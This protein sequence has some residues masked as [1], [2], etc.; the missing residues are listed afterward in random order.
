[1]IEHIFPPRW[2]NVV[3]FAV[4]ATALYLLL[5]WSAQAR[6]MRLSLSIV[7]LFATANLAR[8]LDLVITG[9]VIEASAWIMT[10]LLLI[11][12]Q[13]ELR[14][15]VM[16]VEDRFRGRVRPDAEREATARAIAGAALALARTRTGA[17]I[18]VVGNNSIEELC[19][20]GVELEA[21]V[22]MDLLVA[23][24]Q[25]DSPLH[26]GAVIIGQ[27][28]IQRAGA[29]LPL[30]QRTDLPPFYGTRHRAAIGLADRS[31]ARVIVVSEERGEVTCLRQQERFHANSESAVS[32]WLSRSTSPERT[33][34][35]RQVL[36]MFSVNLR[37]KF[38]AIGLAAVVWSLFFFT[39][40]V[41]VRQLRVPIE[42]NNVGAGLDVTMQS[43]NSVEIQVKGPSWLVESLDPTQAAVRFDLRTAREG[44]VTLLVNSSVV[45]LPFGVSLEKSS[46]AR[47]EVRLGK[48]QP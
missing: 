14:R 28:H 3:D 48:I 15:M 45:Q 20:G 27:E 19:G 35:R 6:A 38:S 47:V 36:Q 7:A 37:L 16:H 32:G 12:F 40:G 13:H 18:V 39:T 11:A 9:W 5:K 1:V 8:R 33:S 31:D 42:F 4:L 24:F 41:T 30:S 23:L 10:G 43:A 2:Q 34:V 22:S 46:P 21:R 44:R 17:L 25:K 26:D 29:L